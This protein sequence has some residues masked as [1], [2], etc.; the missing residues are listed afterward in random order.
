MNPGV[1]ITDKYLQ[2]KEKFSF[3]FN[4]LSFCSGF[5][6]IELTVSILIVFIL[7]SIGIASYNNFSRDQT[8]KQTAADLK[9]NLRMAQ[10][11][12]L[13]GEKICSPDVC[14][15]SNNI[16][17]GE[18]DEKTLIGWEVSIG[19]NNYSIY[20]I[21]GDKIFGKETFNLAKDVSTKN[22]P[23][24][25]RFKSLIGGVESPINICLSGFNRFY[26]ISVTLSGEIIDYG[27]VKDC[28]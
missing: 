2:D 26:K 28:P 7:T 25:V 19:T 15:G 11:K 16:C 21:C 27:L 1:R 23:L 9:N 10:N 18:D 22:A 8:I 5:T 24:T 12:A 4:I 17:D 6:L 13:N 3:I 14:G 20:G